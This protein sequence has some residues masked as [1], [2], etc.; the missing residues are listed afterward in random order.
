MR[1]APQAIMVKTPATKTYVG[2]AKSVPDSLTPRRFI[3][4][5]STITPIAQA[6]LCSTTNGIAE[7]R[8]SM[9]EE[10]DTATVR[11]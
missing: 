4:V 10:I 5:S 1:N 8:F 3:S 9:P 2:T 6:T 7:P 11:T